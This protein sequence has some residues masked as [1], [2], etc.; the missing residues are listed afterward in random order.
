MVKDSPNGGGG[1]AKPLKIRNAAAGK[2]AEGISVSN[3]PLPTQ[4]KSEGGGANKRNQSDMVP[5]PT[6]RRMKHI[7]L[8]DEEINNILYNSSNE[9]IYSSVATF[10]LGLVVNLGM[11]LF[12]DHPEPY[13]EFEKFCLKIA[14]P[15]LIILSVIFFIK[16]FL[17]KGYN[18]KM[19]DRIK[20]ERTQKT[21]T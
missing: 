9:T 11:S 6:V 20:L 3:D 18:K 10:M 15:T 5:E 7:S 14:F 4:T 12:I 13:S 1:N 16:F 8:S 21:N 2:S 19:I 17:G